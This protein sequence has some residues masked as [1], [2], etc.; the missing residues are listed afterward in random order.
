MRWLGSIGKPWR[1]LVHER[2]YIMTDRSRR[3]FMATS[4]AATAAACAP[5][6]FFAAEAGSLDALARGKGLRF[7]SCLGTGPSGAPGSHP[8]TD[9]SSSFGSIKVRRLTEQ[10]CGILVPENELKWYTLRPRSDVF[11]FRRA[12][13]LMAYAGKKKLAVR[14]HT[15]LWNSSRWMLPWLNGIDFGSNPRAAAEKMLID[16]IDKVCRRY[17]ERIFSWDVVNESIDPKTGDLED[18]VFTRAIGPEVVDIAF[19]AARAA[20]PNAQLVYNDYP[21]IAPDN[22][23]HYAGILKL[24]E[25]LKK[26]GV[27]IDA[28]GIQSHIGFKNVPDTAT[29]FSA[30]YCAPWRKFLDEVVG[31]GLDLV[32]TEF[33]V[34][35]KYVKGDIQTRDRAVSDLGKAYLDL[36]L[37][38]R[39]VRYV[40]AWGL[41]NTYSWLQDTSPRED[42]LPKRCCPFDDDFR[43]T[44]LYRA[45]ADA[46]RAAPARPA[47]TP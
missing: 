27:P 43:P 33:D 18:T 13:A 11:T 3:T 24:L 16:H 26:N 10:Q 30:A 46:F 29:R 37:G 4:L 35:D 39:Q 5:S 19:H 6:Y 14:G 8:A 2:G 31:M 45:M 1:I 21:D 9:H 12:D 20:A 28:L 47:L 22:E 7:G 40:M 36:M 32:I 25:R 15:L 42:G 17:G 34:N 44:L 23:R 38:Y 41:V